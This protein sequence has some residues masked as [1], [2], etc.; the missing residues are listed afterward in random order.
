MQA[1][2]E[3]NDI[4][5]ANFKELTAILVKILDSYLP[6]L[7]DR[8]KTAKSIAEYIAEQLNLVKRRK[9]KILIL[10]ALLM[11]SAK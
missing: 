7:N 4:L 2:Q 11:R 3:K 6:G 1:L 8:A 10:R 9:K 5:Q